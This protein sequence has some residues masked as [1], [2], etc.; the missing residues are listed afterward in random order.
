MIQGG[1]TQFP[2]TDDT[3]ASKLI[4][5]VSASALLADRG[6]DTDAVV[7]YAEGTGLEGVMA[8]RKN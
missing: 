6:H 8:L 1:I 7:E 2:T 5:G 3:T 4:D